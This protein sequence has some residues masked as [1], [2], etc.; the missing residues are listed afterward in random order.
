MDVKKRRQGV[1]NFCGGREEG[2]LRQ[3]PGLGALCVPSE[4]PLY[5]RRDLGFPTS[6]KPPGTQGRRLDHV[7]VGTLASQAHG[8]TSGMQASRLN[9]GPSGLQVS[10]PHD[11]PQRP[12]NVGPGVIFHSMTSPS[13]SLTHPK[14]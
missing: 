3:R 8:D 13:S 2:P 7:S 6:L 14:V 9:R 12:I 1:L 4:T 11:D 10:G 5:S